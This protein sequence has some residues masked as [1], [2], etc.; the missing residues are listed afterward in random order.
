MFQNRLSN[1]TRMMRNS[2]QQVITTVHIHS[3][4][5]STS[6]ALEAGVFLAQ[7]HKGEPNRIPYPRTGRGGDMVF[8]TSNVCLQLNSIWIQF[9]IPE[10]RSANM[11]V[12]AAT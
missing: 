12:K 3:I 7:E 11:L 4:C 8:Q 5:Q 9:K 10:C 1:T 6:S 2:R